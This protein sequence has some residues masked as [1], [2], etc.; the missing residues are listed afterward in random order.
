M[1]MKVGDLMDLDSLRRAMEGVDWVFHVAAIADYWR[2]PKETI[3]RVNIEGARNV[4]QAALDVGVKRFVLTGSSAELGIPRGGKPLMDE[5]DT[6]NVSESL[7]P[8]AFSKQ[9]ARQVMLEFVEKGLPV[10]SVLPSAVMGPRDLKFNSGELIVQALK[11]G[12]LPFPKGGLNFVD[13]GDCVRGHIAAAEKGIPG[14]RYLLAGDNMTHQE[15]LAVVN[16][17]LG[18]KAR[19]VAIP[20]FLLSPAG[21]GVDLLHKLGIHPPVDRARMILS[22]QFMYYDNQKARTQLGVTFRPFGESVRAAY[23]WYVENNYLAQRGIRLPS[24]S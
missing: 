20:A 24:A 6:L 5:E 13:T 7:F 22:G 21:W 10:M 3:Y 4:M 17:V 14:E 19:S 11:G 1:E 8:Y 2:I 15:T 16:E 23:E 9:Q 18:T 12:I